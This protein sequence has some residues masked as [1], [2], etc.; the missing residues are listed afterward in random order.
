MSTNGTD[1][2]IVNRNANAIWEQAVSA[3]E[4]QDPLLLMLLLIQAVCVD[5]SENAGTSYT[6]REAAKSLGIQGASK[7]AKVPTK[8]KKGKASAADLL[9]ALQPSA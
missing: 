2:V 7:T 3:Y 5:A 9:K 8:P 4:D 1:V 6:V